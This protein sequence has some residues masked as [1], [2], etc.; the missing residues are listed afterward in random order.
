MKTWDDFIPRIAAALPDCTVPAMRLALKLAAV[1]FYTDSRAWR[2]ENVD[3]ATTVAGTEVYTVADVPASTKLVGLPAVW[4]DDTEVYELASGETDDTYPG[5]T[6]SDV[7]VGVYSADEIR[8][9]PVPATSGGVV[10][11]TVAYAPTEDALGIDDALF[12]AHHKGIGFLAIADLKRNVGKPWSDAAGAFRYEG[13]AA[14]ELMLA[15]SSAGPLR[16]RP[17]LRVRAL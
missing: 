13:D 6:S 9:T 4:I 17:M 3:L 8:I 16:R 14:R 5:E 7:R 1:E 12:Y 2:V 11:G 10:V 15:S